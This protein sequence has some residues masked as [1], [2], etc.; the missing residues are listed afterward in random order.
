MVAPDLE[1]SDVGGQHRVDR[2]LDVGVLFLY[3]VG[4]LAHNVVVV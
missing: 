2:L 3:L 1:D 4:V